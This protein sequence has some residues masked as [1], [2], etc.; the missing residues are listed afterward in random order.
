MQGLN[1]GSYMNSTLFVTEEKGKGP[2]FEFIQEE[3]NTHEE[4]L[5]RWKSKVGL[6]SKSMFSGA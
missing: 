6:R 4:M 2:K 3:D 1:K 5:N